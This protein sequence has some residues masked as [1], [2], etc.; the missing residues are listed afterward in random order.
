MKPLTLSKQIKTKGNF[1]CGNYILFRDSE[2]NL[3][4]I[5]HICPHLGYPL[6]NLPIE[7][8][9]KVTCP[10]HGF[11]ICSNY[12][13]SIN[14]FEYGGIVW[15]DVAD[16]KP[17][18]LLANLKSRHWRSF[19]INTNWQHLLSNLCDYRHFDKIHLSLGAKGLYDPQF[20]YS[21]DNKL[22]V[23]WKS[24]LGDLRPKTAELYL[25]LDNRGVVN[26]VPFL[27]TYLNNISF[28]VEVDDEN[29]ILLTNFWF[30]EEGLNNNLLLR[31]FVNRI[32]E[33]LVYEDR[34]ILEKI[35]IKPK[36]EFENNPLIH[37]IYNV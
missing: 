5:P 28:V 8:N 4:Y 20:T 19:P 15:E 16:N 32:S 12:A 30:E 9:K 31:F 22:E 10:Y 23:L 1:R 35:K 26:R 11:S 34:K 29:S 27:N 13:D 21:E 14:I 24:K 37:K 25:F 6:D 17:I 7:D 2:D 18:D 3:K 36:L 33:I